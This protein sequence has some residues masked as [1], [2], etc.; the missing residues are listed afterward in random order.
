MAA[1]A[2]QRHH[3][4]AADAQDRAQPSQNINPPT[5]VKSTT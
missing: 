4:A 2:A 3:H 5:V 1:G